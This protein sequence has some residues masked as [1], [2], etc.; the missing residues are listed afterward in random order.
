MV[1]IP[2]EAQIL[3]DERTS[4]NVFLFASSYPEEAIWFNGKGQADDTMDNAPAFSSEF[5]C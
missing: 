3:E 4:K 1:P 5:G 2:A